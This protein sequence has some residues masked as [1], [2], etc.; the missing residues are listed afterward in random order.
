MA[1]RVMIVED[2]VIVAEDMRR[3]LEASGYE[4]AGHAMDGREAVHMAQ[5]LRPDVILMDIFLGGAVDGI[6]AARQ[7]QRVIDTAIIYVSG[8]SN[9]SIVSDAVRSGAS[10]Y[11]V[12]PFQARQIT[13]SIEIALHRRRE[14]LLEQRADHAAPLLPYAAAGSVHARGDASTGSADEVQ[15][16]HFTAMLQRLQALLVDEDVW[17][18]TREEAGAGTRGLRVTPR[19]KEIVR[20]LVCYRRVAKVAEVLGISVHTARNHLKSVFR[21]LD[22]HSQDELLR[23]LLEGEES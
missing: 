18:E 3:N 22:L 7:I 23:Y 8:H 11:I 6:D 9:D 5:H 15:P 12:K 16:D 17:S 13:S 2:E 21:K 14:R 1:D 10:G 4:V 19:E 20:G